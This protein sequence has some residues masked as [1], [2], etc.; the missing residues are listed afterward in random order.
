MIR[1]DRAIQCCRQNQVRLMGRVNQAITGIASEL[2]GLRPGHALALAPSA[3]ILVR[4]L[5]PSQY[6]T[7]IRGLPLAAGTA[8]GAVVVLGAFP[9]LENLISAKTAYETLSLV[10][11]AI[12]IITQELYKDNPE[13][14]CSK[15]NR[16]KAFN[17]THKRK[18]QTARI[19]RRL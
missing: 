19:L 18:R 1:L 12:G 6:A 10:G 7:W 5:S 3:P 13:D 14:G 9:E 8:V 17:Q 4:V 2:P 16:S 11:K 15:C